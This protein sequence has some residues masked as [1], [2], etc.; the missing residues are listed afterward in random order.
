M[1]G[2]LSIRIA[3]ACLVKSIFIEKMPDMDVMKGC[4]IPRETN[5]ISFSFGEKFQKLGSGGDK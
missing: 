2:K 3:A 1:V 4:S 5:C